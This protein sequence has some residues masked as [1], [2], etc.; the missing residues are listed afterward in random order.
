MR[1]GRN[2]ALETVAG[3]TLLERA[4][5]RLRPVSDEVLIVTS[6]AFP[7]ISI[8]GDYRVVT[9]IYPEKGPLGGIYTGLKN[10]VS[11]MNIVVGCDMPFLNTELF[12]YMTGIAEGY[13]AVVPQLEED[14]KEPLHSV[15]SRECT[16]LVHERLR[17]GQLSVHSFIDVLNVRFVD[18]DEI[19]RFDPELMSFFDI[20]YPSDL[21]RA[22]AIADKYDI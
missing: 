7:D 8:K 13:D 20:N 4:Y 10:T 21:E 18:R 5:E 17:N 15:Y 14:M 11:Q 16:D 19:T 12:R 1:M 2:K 3:K 6:K 22:T 9:D